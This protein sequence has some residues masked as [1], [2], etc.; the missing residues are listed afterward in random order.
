MTDRDR[1]FGNTPEA[2]SRTSSTNPTNSREGRVADQRL[3]GHSNQP[4]PTRQAPRVR[5]DNGSN[6]PR[7]KA[8]LAQAS[9]PTPV[10]SS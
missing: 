9:A 8:N 3:E 5:A 10:A 2:L 7:E 1:I 4:A 6:D